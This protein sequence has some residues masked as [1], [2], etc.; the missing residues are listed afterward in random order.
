M[1]T[2]THT[3]IE[4]LKRLDNKTV[5]GPGF[6]V[7]VLD[8]HRIEY[9]EGEKVATIGIDGEFGEDNRV[10]WEIDSNS[11]NGW[12]QPNYGVYMD[13][14]K[15]KEILTRVSKSFDLLGMRHEIV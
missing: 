7:R 1:S 12:N 13:E 8:I 6:I 11:L 5:Q 9:I 4:M 3:T 2:N 14:D 10:I 15:S